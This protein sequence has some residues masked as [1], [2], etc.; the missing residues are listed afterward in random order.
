VRQGALM[1]QQFDMAKGTMLG[2]EIA[3]ADGIL[4][5]NFGAGTALS[6]SASGVVAYRRGQTTR[7][8]AWFD[9][10]GRRIGLAGTQTSNMRW[11]AISAN[12]RIAFQNVS[13]AQIWIIDTD[14]SPPTQFTFSPL[15][16]MSPMWSSD[17][18]WLAFFD[19]DGTVRRKR[20]NGA[21]SEEVLYS[22]GP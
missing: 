3:V 18:S 1:A 9:R 2:N 12:G 13:G 21:G 4:T 22:E 14:R 10:S 6:V 15:A 17:G 7:Q 16:K 19:F 8:L 20:S 11:P 5:S